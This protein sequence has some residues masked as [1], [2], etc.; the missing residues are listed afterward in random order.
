LDALRKLFT[1]S[2]EERL[3]VW[4]RISGA[5]SRRNLAKADRLAEP[6]WQAQRLLYNYIVA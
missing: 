4:Q 2:A 5:L 1:T 3:P 6:K